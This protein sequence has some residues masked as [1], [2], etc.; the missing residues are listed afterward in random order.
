M[1]TSN[2]VSHVI[3]QTVIDQVAE[4]LKECT[5]ALEP[6][7][8]GLTEEERQQLFKMGN[9][10]VATVQKVQSY[11]ETNPEFIPSYMNKDEFAKDVK[12]VTQLTPL[13][14]VAYQL[15]SDLDDTRMLAGSEAVAEALIYYGSVREAAKRGITQSKPIYEELSERFTQR[16]KPKP[17]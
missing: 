16:N 5:I 11:I 7:L 17:E 3:P 10:T 4:K 13:Q 15:A 6:Y 2:R 14:N 8:T 1:S 9:K 12:V